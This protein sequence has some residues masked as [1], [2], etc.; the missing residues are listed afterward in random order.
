MAKGNKPYSEFY[1]QCKYA[2]WSP[3]QRKLVLRHVL[4]EEE[5]RHKRE[6]YTDS[7]GDDL[8][9]SPDQPIKWIRSE[10]VFICFSNKS[11]DD[12][13]LVELQTALNDWNPNPSR[14]FLAKL[15][16][17]M[18][19]HGVVAEARALN[20]KHA[21]AFWYDRLLRAEKS[22]RRWQ[23]AE[24]VSRHSDQLMTTVLRDVENFAERLIKAEVAEGDDVNVMCQDHFKVDLTKERNNIQAVLE[25]NAFVCSLSPGGWHLTTGHIFL[26]SEEH[27]LCLSPACDMV[28]SQMSKWQRDMFGAHLPFIA[29]KL[30][31]QK[32]NSV[33]ENIHS[34]RHLFLRLDDEV[35]L[36]CFSSQEN[37]APH[38]Q[39]LYAENAG[40]FTVGDDFKFTVCRIEKGKDAGSKLITTCCQA[41]VVSQLRH[42]YVLN[43][44]QKLGVSLTRVGLN[45]ADGRKET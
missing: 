43:L 12:N 7:P 10:S 20:N 34:N 24:S 29:V 11:D 1:E 19:A 4:K 5:A 17:V 31:P 38:W 37:S 14:L 35:K 23:V 28:P 25:H 18:D 42:Q 16:A 30:Q 3:D 39:T 40:K 15:R 27:W 41:V 21:L 45:F 44:V 9:W 8:K 26:M 6:M 2:K 22:E 36:F 13:L 33:P 32:H